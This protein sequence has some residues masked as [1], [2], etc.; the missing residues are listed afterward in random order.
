[1]H[2]PRIR[3]LMGELEA[4]KANGPDYQTLLDRKLLPFPFLSLTPLSEAILSAP[5]TAA[6]HTVF[7]RQTA[8]AA[9]FSSARR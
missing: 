2:A 4:R 3:A 5:P 1:M 7:A 6:T 9:T 8:T